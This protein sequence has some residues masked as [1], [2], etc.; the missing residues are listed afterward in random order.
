MTKL[1]KDWL[2]YDE[3]IELT[4]QDWRRWFRMREKEIKWRAIERQEK[5]LAEANKWAKLK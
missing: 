3:A 2:I 1:P 4:P 5:A